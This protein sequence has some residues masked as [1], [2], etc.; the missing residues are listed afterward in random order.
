[1]DVLEVLNDRYAVERVLGE[2]ALGRTMLALDRDRNQ[3]VAI[4]ELLP[5]RMK[6]WKDYDLFHR[7][8]T[9]LRSLSHPGIPAYFD[10]FVIESDDGAPS[11]LF[12]VQE[13]IEGRELQDLLDEEGALDEAQVRDIAEKTL[14]IL[15]YLHT[16]NPPVI[17]RDLKPA[18]LM[19]TTGGD[20]K[21]ID[22]GAVREA[23]T[24]EGVGSTIVGT[25]GYMPPE[26]YTGAATPAT[27]LFALGATCVQL[28]TARPPGELFDGL[29]KFSIPDN[30]PVT[31]GFEKILLRLTE[32]NVEQ[33][34]ATA[35]E[36][37]D[38]LHQGFL[39]VPKAS[40]TGVLP[41]PYRI[42]EPLRPPPGFHL[43]D[44]YTGRSH[45]TI[46][47][48][49]MIAFMLSLPLTVGQFFNGGIGMILGAFIS[50]TIGAMIVSFTH[51]SR[52]E[53]R[54]YRTGVYALGEVT[55][56]FISSSSSVG[57]HLTYR[58]RLLDGSYRHGSL[59]TKDKAYRTLSPGDPIGVIYLPDE[60]TEHVMYA[61]PTKWSNKS[62][63]LLNQRLISQ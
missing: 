42:I 13:Y 44:A 50:L 12:L 40:I 17:H 48:I 49:G 56:R 60:P 36:V 32:P 37:I 8:C 30:L 20:V 57:S 59:S 1:M 34:F 24:A 7:E 47:L 54:V 23:V 46:L 52:N 3:Y 43:R 22:F 35:Q 29:H 5:S 4:K 9:T 15:R 27:D 2:G 26:Q 62:T 25:F 55:G 58:Y 38:E 63:S 18:N 33:R 14:E 39:M 45:L 28:L 41:I 16:L 11:R 10:D 31:L 21:L 61:V 6:R 51:K 53:I 19:M